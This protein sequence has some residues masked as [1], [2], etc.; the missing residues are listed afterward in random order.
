LS[1]EFI[2]ENK[3][4]IND[5]NKYLV[6]KFIRPLKEDSEKNK[7]NSQEKSVLTN[8][9]KIKIFEIFVKY[10]IWYLYLEYKMINI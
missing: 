8:D 2:E 9:E 7:Q 6:N 10:Y 1:K 3:D 4:L 5:F